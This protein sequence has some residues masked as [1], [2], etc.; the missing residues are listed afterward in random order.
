MKSSQFTRKLSGGIGFM[1]CSVCY[2]C[3]FNDFHFFHPEI[4]IRGQLRELSWLYKV[5]KLGI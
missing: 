4:F 3:C 2:C 5:Y 1:F